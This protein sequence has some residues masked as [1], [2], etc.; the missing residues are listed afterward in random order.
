MHPVAEAGITGR[1]GLVD[2]C[3]ASCFAKALNTV[4][5]SISNMHP[6]KGATMARELELRSALDEMRRKKELTSGSH[7]H[8]G[9]YMGD[10]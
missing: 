5:E 8:P 7:I 1:G 6:R 3:S 10:A 2:R 9:K 4:M